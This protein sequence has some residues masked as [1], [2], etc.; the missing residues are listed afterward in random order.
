MTNTDKKTVDIA[1]TTSK[2]PSDKEKTVTAVVTAPTLDRDYDIVDTASLRLPLR[3][4]GTVKAKALSG[5]EELDIPFMVNHSMDVTNVIGSARKASMNA[6]GELEMTFGLAS[7]ELAQTMYK[8]LSE[9][10]LGNSFSITFTDYEVENG[11][12]MDAEV[13]EVSLVWR[14]S[15]KDAR[16]LGV[17]KMFN[18]EDTEEESTDATVDEEETTV[19]DETETETKEEVKTDEESQTNNTEEED[20]ADDKDESETEDKEINKENNKMTEEQKNAAASTVVEKAVDVPAATQEKKVVK[21]DKNAIRKNFV[22]QLKAVVAKNSDLVAELAN[23]GAE[24]ENVETKGLSLNGV[25]LS[26]VLRSDVAA[27]YVD[28]GGVGELV[29]R[30]DITGATLLQ[31]PVETSGVG[32]IAV[33]LGAVKSEDQPTWSTVEIRPF[34]Y[35]KITTWFDSA[36]EQTPIAVYNEL[37]RGI[38]SDLKKLEDQ[39]I[40]TMDAATVGSESRPATGLVP[41]LQTAARSSNL[42]SFASQNLVPALGTAFGAIESDG[43]LTLVANRA[44]W[45]QIAT[46]LDGEYNPVFKAVGKQVSVGALGTL[47]IV[48]SEVLDTET[49]VIGDFSDYTLV[50]RGG[51]STLFSQEAVVGD[52]N[53]FTQDGSGIRAS[54]NIAGAPRRIKSFYLLT[55][56][57]YVS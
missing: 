25:Y 53:L 30:E 1:L 22:S 13:L 17:S 26:S 7:T 5:T 14:G 36:A 54:I 4:G 45:A 57:G 56:Q 33:A 2:A 35:A 23:K 39:I 21:V 20:V 11:L 37:V 43:Q 48:T 8:L 3:S 50:T 46:S 42:A 41:M 49:I 24:L 6:Q 19:V 32:F 40:L 27:A 44:T 29:N 34:E 52:V 10:H 28:A 38:A 18:T 31:L 51:L 15:N 16:L 55:T 9:G 12:M 47:N